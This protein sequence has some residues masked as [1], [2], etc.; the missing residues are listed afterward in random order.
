MSNERVSVYLKEAAVGNLLCL[1]HH[2]KY[3]CNTK[4]LLYV[5]FSN[6]SQAPWTSVKDAGYKFV[7]LNS[8]ILKNQYE[9]HHQ[10]VTCNVMKRAWCRLSAIISSINIDDMVEGPTRPQGLQDGYVPLRL[11]IWIQSPRTLW[12]KEKTN[13]YRLSSDYHLISGTPPTHS[14]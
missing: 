12:K 2:L 5:R 1:K 3:S 11:V 6:S 8:L 9:P 10:R 14:E 13:F 4:S 7:K